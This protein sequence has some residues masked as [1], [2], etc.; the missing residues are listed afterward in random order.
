MNINEVTQLSNEQVIDELCKKRNI[1]TTIPTLP[2]QPA[3]VMRVLHITGRS[4]ALSIAENGLSYNFLITSTTRNFIQG[5]LLTEDDYFSSDRRFV[6]GKLLVFDVPNDIFIH[7]ATINN[8]SPDFKTV[9]PSEYLV[10]I[11]ETKPKSTYIIEKRTPEEEVKLQLNAVADYV[12]QNL[13]DY[14]L[15][16]LFRTEQLLT[17]LERKVV[18]DE[19]MSEVKNNLLIIIAEEREARKV[20]VPEEEDTSSIW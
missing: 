4:G 5:E 12:R 3:G 10:G 9:L 19:E 6:A 18:F 7:H 1:A 8:R 17:K 14:T 15:D 20:R 13:R 2:D 16:E 11:I